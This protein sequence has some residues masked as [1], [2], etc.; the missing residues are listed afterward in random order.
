MVDRD[1]DMDGRSFFGSRLFNRTH[2]RS[3]LYS[4]EIPPDLGPA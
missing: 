4:L 1:G 2:A 3:D